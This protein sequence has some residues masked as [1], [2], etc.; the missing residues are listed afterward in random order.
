VERE[1][2]AVRQALVALSGRTCSAP[3]QPTLLLEFLAQVAQALDD[4][5]VFADDL[6][7]QNEELLTHRETLETERQQYLHLFEFAPDG[8]LVTEARHGVSTPACPRAM[9]MSGQERT[10]ER[11]A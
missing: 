7:V 3:D 5:Q 8:F 4:L 2:E 9:R 6:R 10:S 1:L 11:P